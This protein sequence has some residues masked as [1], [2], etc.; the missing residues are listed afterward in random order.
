MYK[1][2]SLNWK[3]KRKLQA[4]SVLGE[5]DDDDEVP[6]GVDWLTA[7]KKSKVLVLEDNAAKCK[8]LQEEG[9]LLAENER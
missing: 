8:R 2:V 4:I 6:E 9:I 5:E 7:T 3:R 1:M